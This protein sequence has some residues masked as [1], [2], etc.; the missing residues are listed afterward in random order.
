M[1]VLETP[2]PV[3]YT[4]TLTPEM[5]YRE[6]IVLT[7]KRNRAEAWGRWVRAV[8]SGAASVTMPFAWGV[9]EIGEHDA[10]VRV[11]RAVR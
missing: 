2:E 9:A 3:Q 5:Y 10:P 6:Y 1:I 11:V 4:L 7:T 8:E